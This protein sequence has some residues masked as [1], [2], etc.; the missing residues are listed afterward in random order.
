MIK[1]QYSYREQPLPNYTTGGKGA[2]RSLVN[3]DSTS[4]ANLGPGWEGADDNAL[5]GG[6]GGGG[7]SVDLELCTGDIARVKG[8][9]LPP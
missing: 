8:Y 2:N 1:D 7:P 9:I 6:G 4:S 5:F 3:L